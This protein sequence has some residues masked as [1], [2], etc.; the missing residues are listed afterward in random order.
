MTP[1][2]AEWLGLAAADGRLPRDW[3][4]GRLGRQSRRRVDMRI[5]HGCIRQGWV[6]SGPRFTITDAGRAALAAHLRAES[7]AQVWQPAGAEAPLWG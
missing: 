6:Q 5:V 4:S 1:A 3:P 2:Q 7:A